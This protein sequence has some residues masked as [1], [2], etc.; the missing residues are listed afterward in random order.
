[1]LS[2][3]Y[4]QGARVRVHV[5]CEKENGN[6]WCVYTWH[7]IMHHNITGVDAKRETNDLHESIKKFKAAMKHNDWHAEWNESPHP[8]NLA[9]FGEKFNSKHRFSCEHISRTWRH[10]Q[11][12]SNLAC[13]TSTMA[14]KIIHE[15]MFGWQL[16]HNTF[17]YLTRPFQKKIRIPGDNNFQPI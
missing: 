12:S 8:P 16:F 10:S 1:M 17:S 11:N 15:Q 2:W 4:L 6:G 7:Y 14:G 3:S 9:P 13:T 5:K